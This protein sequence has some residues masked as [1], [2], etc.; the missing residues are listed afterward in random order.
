MSN[1]T[2]R[3]RSGCLTWP[4]H[5]RTS[6]WRG[7]GGALTNR[8]KERRMRIINYNNKS[9]FKVM[10]CVNYCR[11][12]GQKRK[13]LTSYLIWSQQG[14]AFSKNWFCIIGLGH[15][16]GEYSVSLKTIYR[17]STKKFTLALLARKLKLTFFCRHPVVVW[18]T[19]I[20]PLSWHKKIEL[21]WY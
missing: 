17:V 10:L 13:K 5:S 7:G 8:H 1:V 18:G 6:L 11:S 14:Q 3:S 21:R 4:P 9:V 20:Y 12:R 19:K 2:R 16:L 15:G